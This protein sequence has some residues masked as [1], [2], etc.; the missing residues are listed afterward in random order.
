MS[1]T[2]GYVGNKGLC[3]KQGVMSATRGYVGNKGLCVTL[4]TREYVLPPIS[5]YCRKQEVIYYNPE[6][7]VCYFG[8]KGL[9]SLIFHKSL[10]CDLRKLGKKDT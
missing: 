2:R 7:K 1:E 5:F 4:E 10:F 3:R 6:N 8:N 9:G